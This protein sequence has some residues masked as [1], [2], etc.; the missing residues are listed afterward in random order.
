MPIY[1]YR[2]ESCAVIF[3]QF[4]STSQVKEYESGY[5]CPQCSSLCKKESVYAVSSKFGG[6]SGNSGFHDVDYPT[7][8]KAVGRDSAKRWAKIS[9][10]QSVRNKI[11][12][13]NNTNSITMTDKGF[14]PTTQS[15]LDRRSNAFSKLK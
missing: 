7:L 9:E 8:D 11:R 5:P 4:L 3:E 1:D 2:C 13:E 14:E 12:K 10:D 15:D 6:E